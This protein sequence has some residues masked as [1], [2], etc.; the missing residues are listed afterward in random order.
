MIDKSNWPSLEKVMLPSRAFLLSWQEQ[1][2]PARSAAIEDAVDHFE[3]LGAEAS[4]GARDY[5][6]LGV[7]G[8]AIQPLEDLAYLA[9]AWDQPFGGL[10]NYVRATVYSSFTASNFWQ[11][12]HK[13]D[14]EYLD[15]L[16][17]YSAR[18]SGS[19]KTED[20]LE[21]LVERVAKEALSDEQLAA[22]DDARQVTRNRLR[23]L[24][25]A[26]GQDWQQFSDYFYAYKHGGLAVHRPDAAWVDDDVA[27][28]EDSTPRRTPAIAV[29]HR[30]G[31]ALEGRGEF[32]LS[33]D[34]IVRTASGTG[35][36]G[37]D[38]VDAFVHSRLA[39]F[40]AVE[41]ANDGSVVGLRPTQLPWT[42]WLR[43]A[44]LPEDV[45]KL[46]GRGPRLT[47]IGGNEPDA[48]MKLDEGAGD[49]ASDE[50]A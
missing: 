50:A 35:R 9:T 14:E 49:D 4:D 21:G 23:R 38:L 34:E 6:V 37:V 42:I 47:W 30:G 2:L 36:L 7:I 28:L 5:A 29:W 18:D 13:R 31:K 20:I 44:D 25:G 16:A 27:E 40:D 39:V 3:R 32:K 43:E 17:G 11:R 48:R 45:W 8:E 22:L 12:I 24:L 41:F 46:I 26:L 19:G 15:V 1:T 33:A 10:A